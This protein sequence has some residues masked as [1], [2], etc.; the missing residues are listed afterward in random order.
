MR[1][2]LR[3]PLSGIAVPVPAVVGWLLYDSGVVAMV[4]L[5][6]LL[7]AWVALRVSRHREG[8]ERIA[9]LA[10]AGVLGCL[11][12][13][14]FI[15]YGHAHDNPP[16]TAEPEW[17]RP[18]TRVLAVRACFDC[19]SNETEWPWYADIAPVSW[20]TTNHIVE[21]RAALDFSTW[22]QAQHEAEEAGETIAEGEMPPPYYTLLHPQARLSESEKQQLIDGLEATLAVSPPG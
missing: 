7:L 2:L 15:P 10:G 3:N 19:H 4:L 14:Q 9:L 22:D 8:V 1:D 18:E 17:D 12:V 21:G 11:A 20:L 5:A 13:L 16:V 6:S